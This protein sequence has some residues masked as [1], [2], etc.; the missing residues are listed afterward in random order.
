MAGTSAGAKKG[1]LSRPRYTHTVDRLRRVQLPGRAKGLGWKPFTHS[2]SIK[3][4]ARYLRKS[5]GSFARGLKTEVKALGWKGMFEKVLEH[6][7]NW[8]PSSSRRGGG[9]KG[10]GGRFGG[11][12]AS[13]RW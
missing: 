13:S 12:G 6:N 5:T 1:W 4:A 11:G 7:R 9:S 8:N 10:G 3:T 2:H